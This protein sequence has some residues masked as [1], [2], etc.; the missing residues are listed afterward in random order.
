MLG[1]PGVRDQSTP[2]QKVV[3]SELQLTSRSSNV[4]CVPRR[5]LPVLFFLRCGALE[6]CLGGKSRPTSQER[7]EASLKIF[8]LRL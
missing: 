7:I 2:L 6:A 5:V 3:K 8:A 1:G 4:Q